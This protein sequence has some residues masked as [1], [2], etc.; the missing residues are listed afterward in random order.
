MGIRLEAAGAAV[1]RQRRWKQRE[2]NSG[3]VLRAACPVRLVAHPTQERRVEGSCHP[4][5]CLGDEADSE[6][7]PREHNEARGR[8]QRLI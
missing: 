4:S 5:F 6:A 7:T 3:D 2:S 1:L 8:R